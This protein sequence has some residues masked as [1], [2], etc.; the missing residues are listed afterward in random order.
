MSN[1]INPSFSEKPMTRTSLLLGVVA[2]HLGLLFLFTRTSASHLDSQKNPEDLRLPVPLKMVMVDVISTPAPLGN[3]MDPAA[4]KADHNP[5]NLRPPN[6]KPSS[7]PADQKKSEPVQTAKAEPIKQASGPAQ[8]SKPAPS[9]S[10][11]GQRVATTSLSAAGQDGQGSGANGS[12]SHSEGNHAGGESSN[13][14]AEK[15]AS[16]S[17][18]PFSAP[19]FGAAYLNNPAPQY[20]PLCKRLGEQGKVMLRVLVSAE[21]LAK[22]VLVNASS[23]SKLLDKAALNAVKHWRFIPAKQGELSVTAWVQVPILFQL[24]QGESK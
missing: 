17:G 2:I 21:G 1:P 19:R 15:T 3:T 4:L 20:P 11:S 8:D 18:G 5:A 10:S 22:E 14:S 23:G 24:N 13:S 7:K 6:P 16:N 12:H 9:V